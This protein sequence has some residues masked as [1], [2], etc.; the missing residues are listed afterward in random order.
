MV[1]PSNI[2][3]GYGLRRRL[4]QRVHLKRGTRQEPIEPYEG[5]LG[6]DKDGFFVGNG[7]TYRILDGNVIGVPIGTLKIVRRYYRV[8]L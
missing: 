3:K 6:M 4:S 1:Q 8:V 5:I 2:I 7:E